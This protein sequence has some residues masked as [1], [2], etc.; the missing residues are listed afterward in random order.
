MQYKYSHN[1]IPKKL[2]GIN[3]FQVLKKA[4]KSFPGGHGY[5]ATV[6][7]VEREGLIHLSLTGWYTCCTVQGPE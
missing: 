7:G 6:T 5:N 3:L 1:I 4:E 2:D